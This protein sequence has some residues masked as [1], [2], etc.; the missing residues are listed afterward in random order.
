MDDGGRADVAAPQVV[1]DAVGEGFEGADD[2]VHD[3]EGLDGR[4]VVGSPDLGDREVDAALAR[5][6]D[7]VIRLRAGG[8]E[9][10]DLHPTAGALTD[11]DGLTVIALGQHR[12]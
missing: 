6:E 7:Q 10:R 8:L 11:L 12:I 4:D 9:V 1:Q 2:A 3:A 5:L